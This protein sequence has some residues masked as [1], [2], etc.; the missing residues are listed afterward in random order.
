MTSADIRWLVNGIEQ[1]VYHWTGSLGS[2]LCDTVVIGNYTFAAY[3]DHDF[4]M[5]SE[6]P[7]GVPDSTLYQ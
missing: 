2:A 1:P 6:F 4:I 3:T 7:N 5:W